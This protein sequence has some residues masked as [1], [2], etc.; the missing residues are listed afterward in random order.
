M[1]ADPDYDLAGAI[2]R[3]APGFVVQRKL[4]DAAAAAYAA[5][6]YQP[7]TAAD[8]P[9]ILTAANALDQNTLPALEYPPEDDPYPSSLPAY[10]TLL[11]RF[12]D[13]NEDPLDGWVKYGLEGSWFA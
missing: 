2:T 1:A 7:L 10:P 5:K 8:V 9:G 11:P 3:L 13:S 4:V 6:G 12:P